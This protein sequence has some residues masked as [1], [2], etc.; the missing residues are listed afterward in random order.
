MKKIL[1]L[2]LALALILTPVLCLA[3]GGGTA[4][5]IITAF[6]DGEYLAGSCAVSNGNYWARCMVFLRGGSYF[7]LSL[8]VSPSGVFEC[9]ITAQNVLRIGVELRDAPGAPGGTVY[10]FATAA[11]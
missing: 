7:I 4:P 10:D 11:M 1:A 5:H 2:I 9:H 8:P 3:A 6:Y